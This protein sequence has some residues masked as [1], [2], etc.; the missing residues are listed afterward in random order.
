MSDGK[1]L[2]PAVAERLRFFDCDHLPA[3][4]KKIAQPMRDLAWWMAGELEGTQLTA[5]L[6]R[7]LEAKDCFVRAALPPAEPKRP[8]WTTE[9]GVTFQPPA[10]R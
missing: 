9:T 3:P 4:L 2:H 8:E 5:G 7:L 6:D 10:I 1:A